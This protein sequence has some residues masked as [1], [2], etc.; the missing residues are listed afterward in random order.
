[1][2]KSKEQAYQDLESRKL[3]AMARF[4]VDEHDRLYAEQST[5][6]TFRPWMTHSFSEAAP[7]VIFH[8]QVIMDFKTLELLA[9]KAIEE[10]EARRDSSRGSSA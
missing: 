4:D 2:P 3:R 1:V 9:R 5:L 6:V 8:G 10:L 7:T